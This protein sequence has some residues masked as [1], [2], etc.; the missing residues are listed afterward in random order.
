[1]S[2]IALVPRKPS[3]T[4]LFT[5]A[6]LVAFAANSLLCRLALSTG[7][8]DAFSFT[9]I[10]LLSGAVTLGTL[11][12]ARGRWRELLV[13]RQFIGQAISLLLYAVPFSWAYVTLPTGIGA[14][15]L[16]GAVQAT[17]VGAGIWAG[18]RP[19]VGEWAGLL[20]ALAG[21]TYLLWPGAA[22]PNLVGFVSMSIAGI[23]WG[24]FSLRG[25][26]MRSP[27]VGSAAAFVWASPGSVLISLFNLRQAV[28]SYWGLL[29]ALTSGA[30]SSGI[31]YAIWY[32][33]LPGHT[34]TSAAV[35]QLAVPVLAAFAGVLLLGESITSRLI[36]SA[37]ATLGGVLLAILSRAQLRASS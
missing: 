33:A 5:V 37:I 12:A 32:A 13:P 10:R 24:Y 1:M 4:P 11:V 2:T 34:A 19:R 18:D 27:L 28:L 3:K 23:A 21:L 36:L 16:F 29:W 14:L 20:I 25:R 17:M 22:R 30:I 31:G 35:T 15:I 9:T 26:G 7:Q 6:A 8:I